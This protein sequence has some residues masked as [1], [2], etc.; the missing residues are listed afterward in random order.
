MFYSIGVCYNSVRSIWII[1]L[2]LKLSFFFLFSIFRWVV[3]VVAHCII[4]VVGIVIFLLH[5]LF[6]CDW[7]IVIFILKL[8]LIWC[9]GVLGSVVIII[10]YYVAC[11]MG[12]LVFLFRFILEF[13]RFQC[14]WMGFMLLNS[15]CVA[16]DVYEGVGMVSSILMLLLL[17]ISWHPLYNA[18]V[19]TGFVFTI[20]C[21]YRILFEVVSL[22][23]IC[24]IVYISVSRSGVEVYDW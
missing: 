9:F 13:V 20:L 16:F 19:F 12:V 4:C 10:V 18:T 24:F 2:T 15:V 21:C 11:V 5:L 23:V 22:V 3:I 6:D 14:V 17:L 8:S 7:G 1:L